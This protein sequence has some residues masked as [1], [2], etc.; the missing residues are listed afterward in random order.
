MRP[1]RAKEP[2][3]VRQLTSQE[4]SILMPLIQGLLTANGCDSPLLMQTKHENSPFGDADTAPAAANGAKD[5][6]AAKVES[7]NSKSLQGKM[8]IKKK[9]EKI[10]GKQ[11]KR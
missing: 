8:P 4:E 11:V 10:D 9:T 7:E 3:A 2:S 6:K 1:K 5:G